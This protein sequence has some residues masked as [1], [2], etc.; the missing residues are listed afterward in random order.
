MVL[1]SF[2]ASFFCTVLTGDG[3]RAGCTA[4][5][6]QLSK[7]IGAVRFLVARGKPLASQTGVAVRTA[8]TL[9]VPWLVTIRYTTRL[10]DLIAFDAPKYKSGEKDR[11][12]RENVDII[13]F[14]DGSRRALGL[15]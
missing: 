12:V 3:P 1:F 11:Q 6:K 7:T 14:A 2:L 5:S 10:N 4:F 13:D 8:E 9:T 15:Y